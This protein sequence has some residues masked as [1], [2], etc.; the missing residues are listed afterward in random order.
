MKPQDMNKILLFESINDVISVKPQLLGSQFIELYLTDVYG[1]VIAN[2]GG[3]NLMIRDYDND[4]EV[5]LL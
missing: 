1:N 3:G 2:K 5:S 4:D